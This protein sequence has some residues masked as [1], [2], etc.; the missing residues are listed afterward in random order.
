[1]KW[2]WEFVP[3]QC[4]SGSIRIMGGSEVEGVRNMKDDMKATPKFCRTGALAWNGAN[5]SKGVRVL[6]ISVRYLQ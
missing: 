5:G 2:N 4:D 3:E 6:H 1:M